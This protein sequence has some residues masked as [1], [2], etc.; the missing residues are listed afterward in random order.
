MV[1]NG[2]IDVG[3][4]LEIHGEYYWIN[5]AN[6]SIFQS[7]I[8]DEIG[9]YL[10]GIP[11]ENGYLTYNVGETGKSFSQRLKQHLR[12][13]LRG[14]YTIYDSK[15]WKKGAQKLLWEG[16]WRDSYKNREDE[17]LN[18]YPSLSKHLYNMLE[19]MRLFV[20]PF[21]EDTHTR[22]K[23]EY[24]I[25]E[26]LKTNPMSSHF[27]SKYE[28]YNEKRREDETP[29]KVTFVDTKNIIGLPSTIII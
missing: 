28:S 25:A 24:S 14:N 27:F 18:Q 10:W 11:H 1:L 6:K 7:P 3:Y 13:Y 20:V 8:A 22:R 21:H 19:S 5:E 29:I 23:L 26:T 9:I 15:L 2:L 12:E 17:F 4:E 16:M